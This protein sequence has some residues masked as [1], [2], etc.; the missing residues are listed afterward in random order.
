MN[1][2]QYQ[3]ARDIFDKAIELD[4]SRRT[5]FVRQACGNDQS[6]LTEVKKMIAADQ[7]EN[8]LLDQ[9]IFHWNVMHERT[10]EEQSGDLPFNYVGNYKL[11]KKLG[12]GGMGEV[13]LAIE[14]PLG[15][16]VAIKLMQPGLPKEY[17]QR[18]NDERR[19][20]ATLN[21]RNIVT[22]FT[23]GEAYNRPYFVMEYLEGE[24]LRERLRRGRIPVPE[25]VEITRQIC[26]A[27]NAAHKQGIVHRD[28]K[29]ENIFLTQDDDGK[30]VKV[31]DFGIATLKESEART[32]TS[33]IVGTAP[34]LSPEQAKGLSR[35]EIDGRAD[36][37]SLGIVVYEMLIGMRTFTATDTD[38]YRH[39]HLN[40]TPQP[41]SE[42]VN[43]PEISPA[44]DE[45]VI[46]AL[47]KVPND[48][49]DTA[50]DF[51]QALKKAVEGVP[52]PVVPDTQPL[53]KPF[54]SR[55]ALPLAALLVLMLGGG[56]WWAYTQLNRPDK[57]TTTDTPSL[58]G[59][60]NPTSGQ[61]GGNTP[62]GANN[63]GNSSGTTSTPTG[64]PP[65]AG[66][67]PVL[68][69]GLVQEG[70]GPLLSEKLFHNGDAVRLVATPNQSGHIYILMK[71]T[72][73]PAEVLYPDSRIKGSFNT[74]QA[75]QKIEMPSSK[76][77]MPWFRFDAHPGT[78]R[79][80]VIFAAQQG[81][82]RLQT[83]E[84]AI[85]QN[86]RKLTD[87]EEQQTLTAVETLAAGQTASS[88]VTAKK[89][90]LRHVK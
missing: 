59:S 82:E 66:A 78:E 45:V 34:Y 47:A 57:P 86:R 25:V 65:V 63:Q 13:Y 22:M 16:K 79:L 23:S 11:V 71:G 33:I 89:I 3:R 36:I 74:V 60:G 38:G 1:N 20:L 49:F 7:Q 39:L 19:V 44:I 14:E 51:A 84:A 5:A 64:S 67:Q 18:F 56:G 88:T 85:K 48:R 6:L 24:S 29:P 90:E 12:E 80:Y 31:L 87:A 27:L 43:A 21:Q 8:S 69:V 70:K 28:I 41:P 61:I 40:V 32:T 4:E 26:D 58:N 55:Y 15:R 77:P 68:N 54:L 52:A 62:N 9:P 37:Y 50:R 10:H 2:G 53:E 17:L 46:K 73:G 42:R 30:L 83:L 75:N 81:D 76:N 35:E 72:T